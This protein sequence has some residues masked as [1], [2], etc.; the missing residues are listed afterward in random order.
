MILDGQSLVL[1]S[2]GFWTCVKTERH[3]NG[4]YSIHGGQETARGTGYGRAGCSSRGYIL[5]DVPP[6][7]LCI[8]RLPGPQIPP[9]ARTL[10]VPEPGDTSSLN[11][12]CSAF[13]IC[14]SLI[15]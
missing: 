6:A 1:G 14:F 4:G 10:S 15:P 9:L 13:Y 8:L 12:K 7:K 5:S 3:R 2:V 11:S